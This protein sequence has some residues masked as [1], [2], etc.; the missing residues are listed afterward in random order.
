LLFSFKL[1]DIG[2]I[3]NLSDE[4]LVWQNE[5]HL[6]VCPHKPLIWSGSTVTPNLENPT[7]LKKMH[8][9][10]SL[11]RQA[12]S[13]FNRTPGA[14]HAVLSRQPADG[15]DDEPALAHFEHH[16]PCPTR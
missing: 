11:D 8:R 14:R 9:L 7:V 15:P 1:G 5:W 12:E 4:R 3:H 10:S 13:E 2:A 6:F 16:P